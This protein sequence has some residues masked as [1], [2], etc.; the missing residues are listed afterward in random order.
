MIEFSGVSYT[1]PQGPEQQVLHDVNVLIKRGEYVVLTGSNGSGKSTMAKCMNGLCTPTKGTVFVEGKSVAD[2]E[3]VWAIRQL[4]GYIFQ[5]PENQFVAATVM[6]DVAFGLENIGVDSQEM[7]KRIQQALEQ[8]DMWLHKDFEPHRLSG[9]QMQRVAIA[10]VLAM[11]MDILIFDEATS[12]IDPSGRRKIG[13][14]IKQ[15]HEQGFTI[16]HITH[17]MN[18]ALQAERMII[19][20]EGNIVADGSPKHILSQLDLLRGQQLDSPFVFRAVNWFR[21]QG[22][23]LPEH[24]PDDEELVNA[25]WTLSV[26]K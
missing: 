8:V 4:V 16:V 15:F 3:Q 2:E 7:P 17:D 10:G 9:G 21:Q 1:Y 25:L 22:L 18:E 24:I 26:E 5:N 12:M 13:Q 19:L 23:T 14:L 11:H 6:D 20:G